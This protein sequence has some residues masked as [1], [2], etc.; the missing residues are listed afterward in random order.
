[1][2]T[3]NHINPYWLP[4]VR[5]GASMKTRR[6]ATVALL[7]SMVML[8]L[9]FVPSGTHA[10]VAGSP[11][12]SPTP[13]THGPTSEPTAVVS[14]NA[15]MTALVNT[16]QS[17][18]SLMATSTSPL[19]K[20]F[21]TIQSPDNVAV[22]DTTTNQ[23]IPSSIA[24]PARPGLAAITPDGTQLFVAGHDGGGTIYGFD[25]SSYNT[26]STIPV[27]GVDQRGIAINPSGSRLYVADNFYKTVT[28]IDIPAK[29]PIA[30]IQLSAHP[31]QIALSPD[32]SQ[33]YVA[34]NFPDTNFAIDTTDISKITSFQAGTFPH[35]VAVSLDGQRIFIANYDTGTV[36]VVDSNLNPITTL[37]A[38]R[39]ASFLRLTA[40]GHIL[41]VM[42]HDD[43]S[44]T[45][46][47]AVA[48]TPLKTVSLSSSPFEGAISEDGTKLYIA[49]ADGTVAILNTTTTNDPPQYVRVNTSGGVAISVA[50]KSVTGQFQTYFDDFSSHSLGSIPSGWTSY[51][52][53]KIQPTVINF[54]GTGSRFQRLD[55]PE[56]TSKSV[57]KWLVKD[58]FTFDSVTASVKLN[59]QTSADGAGLVL[60]WRDDKNYISI[61]P[62][63]F[64]DEIVVREFVNGKVRSAYGT[65]QFAVPIET[66]RDYW[67][68]ANTKVSSMGDRQIEV[69]WSTDG[70]NYT[71][72]LT[73][74]HLDNLVGNVGV[75]T[76][77][78]LS[79]TL[80]DDFSLLGNVIHLQP[81]TQG[82][83][84]F[85]YHQNVTGSLD[86]LDSSDPTVSHQGIDIWTND[87]N[88]QVTGMTAQSPK[89]NAVYAPYS[90]VVVGIFDANNHSVPARNPKASIILIQHFDGLY[91]LYAHMA[92]DKGNETYID[93]GLVV[94]G[95]VTKGQPL[96]FQGNA[97]GSVSPNPGHITHLHFEVKTTASI[98]R[99]IDPSP[100]LQRQVNRCSLGHPTWGSP[101]P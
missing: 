41:Y 24:S 88:S 16:P 10:T 65:G 29:Q 97:S 58:G 57:S 98:G 44:V 62:N 42:S 7:L 95:A 94:G 96:G 82:Y 18:T 15:S 77:Q 69:A 55:F 27:A 86:C 6:S 3:P 43:N 30:T 84:G 56:Y 37:Q 74:I 78:F 92:N 32:G 91:T 5:K 100:Y 21:V 25:T 53:P 13:S 17:S 61:L 72:K 22:L 34:A 48:L 81:P 19:N 68:M 51:G 50:T 79:H 36:S 35:G 66:N 47:D 90:G 70:T 60:A 83:L 59:F 64:W 71:K 2:N 40:D 46:I 12:L 38:R 14:P 80:F 85:L 4:K 52:T 20:A 8:I 33:L 67:L 45:L 93:S 89:G 99:E 39:G 76:Y 31:E 9:L 11:S 73:A 75:G 23:P 101:F 1:M 63:P 26:V 49:L 87:P 54:G 28:V